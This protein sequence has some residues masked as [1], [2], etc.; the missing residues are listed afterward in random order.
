VTLHH[1]L[2]GRAGEAK[3]IGWDR[4]SFGRNSKV[5][6]SWTR[7]QINVT[8]G[9]P[10]SNDVLVLSC[11]KCSNGKEFAPFAV[12]LNPATMIY[13]RD[14]DFDLAAWETEI[15]GSSKSGP[16]IMTDERVRELCRLTMSKADLARAIQDDCG[17]TRQSAYRYLKRAE[18]ARKIQWNE[19][20]QHYCK[21]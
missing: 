7:G 1:A 15:N 9:S 16:P 12:R 19:K 11:G 2:T 8:P 6:H 18:K 21:R 10:D 14:P 17:C 5:L 13:E 20:G 4:A 3:A